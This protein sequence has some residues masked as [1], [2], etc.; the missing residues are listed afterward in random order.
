[1]EVLQTLESRGKLLTVTNGWLQCPN[2]R[3]NKRLKRISR[4]EEGRGIILYCRDCRQEI[5]VDISQGQ[6][7]ESRSQ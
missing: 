5:A 7:F 2:C 3:R 4:Q 1:M 6:C